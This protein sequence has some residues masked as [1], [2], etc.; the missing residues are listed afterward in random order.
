M[1]D[2]SLNQSGVYCIRN[3]VNDKRYVGSGRSMSVRW[4][5][6]H[7]KELRTGRHGNP[8]LQRAWDKYGEQAFEIS[9]LEACSVERL[10]EREQYWIDTLD[11]TNRC[12][13]YNICP[14]AYSRRGT[15]LSLEARA[16]IAE[17]SRR[18][19]SDPVY[20][21][22]MST[23][24]AAAWTLAMREAK[25]AQQKAYRAQP[26]VRA[27]MVAVANANWQD[28]DFRSRQ[29]AE[30]VR[31]WQEPAYRDA[32]TDLAR[33]NWAKEDYRCRV[34][35][36]V[37]RAAVARRKLTD[38]QIG[39]IIDLWTEHGVTQ[40]EIAAQFGVS[41]ILV[42]HVI[43]GIGRFKRPG[44]PKPERKIRRGKP[45]LLSETDIIE[46][47]RLRADGNGIEWLAERY[48]VSR[49]LIGNIVNGLKAY[50]HL[51]PVRKGGAASDCGD[52]CD[53]QD[54]ISAVL[55]RR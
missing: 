33:Q 49:G 48:G 38:E 30:R 8:Y 9:V 6:G 34:T 16:A 2:D 11:V 44:Q 41:T 1:A 29:R 52:E 43:R 15:Q 53:E 20:R 21:R 37:Q 54:R 5:R 31:R 42:S 39:E 51:P 26:D 19:Q 24:V 12:K 50:A 7:V 55:V 17:A 3:R 28:E 45:K 35:E 22:R 27:R 13:G 14:K 47:R 18:N 32:M 40:D 23:A 10:I 4:R 36:G 25:S 46:I